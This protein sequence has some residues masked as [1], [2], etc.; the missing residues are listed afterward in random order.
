ME[1]LRGI[2]CGV[3]PS[4][5]SVTFSSDE[6][7]TDLILELFSLRVEQDH[8]S[9]YRQHNKIKGR[10]KLNCSNVWVNS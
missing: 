10:G 3:I 5:T 7:A 4:K 6:G 8:L 2:T 9:S 1:S